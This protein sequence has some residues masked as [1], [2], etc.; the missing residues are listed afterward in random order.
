MVLVDSVE[1]DQRVAIQ[2]KAVR[3]R[4]GAKGTPIPPPR[5]GMRASDTPALRAPAVRPA[6]ASLSPLYQRLPPGVQKLHLWA[7]ALPHLEDAEN[8]QREWSTEY[9]AEMHRTNQA[10]SL[11]AIPLIVLTRAEGG[12]GDNLDFPASQLERERKDSQARL[13]QLSTN[14]KQIVLQC[15]HNM[16]LEAPEEVAEAIREVVEAVRHGIRL[17]R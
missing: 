9:F 10:G 11:G 16:H 6:Q 13:T 2:G 1:E 8:S 4:D 14:S 7:E 3:L 12:Y 15:G 17:K 5:A